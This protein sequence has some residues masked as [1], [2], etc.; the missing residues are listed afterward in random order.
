MIKP[1]MAFFLTTEGFSLSSADFSLAIRLTKTGGRILV[2]QW[3]LFKDIKAHW[4]INK[5]SCSHAYMAQKADFYLM[6]EFLNKCAGAYRKINLFNYY[7]E[8]FVL[9]L[10]TRKDFHKIGSMPVG[11]I[12]SNI[13]C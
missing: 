12:L 2:E 13:R 6:I 8:L 7:N 4:V 11:R 9:Q 5:I 1:R 3:M 10:T